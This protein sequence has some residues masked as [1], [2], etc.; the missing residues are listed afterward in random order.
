MITGDHPAT[1]AAVA[2]EVRLLGKHGFVLDAHH[3]PN[4]DEDLAACL[5][6]ENG[7][8]SPASLPARNCVLPGCCANGATS[9]R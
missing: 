1:A 7:A 4:D 3:L 6:G 2:R 5:D 9:W 8:L